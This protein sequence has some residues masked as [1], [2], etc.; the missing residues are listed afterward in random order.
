MPYHYSDPERE[1]ETYSLPDVETF[2]M[3][4]D[5]FVD[6]ESGSWMADLAEGN[7]P[8]SLAGWY[9][10][11]CFPGCVPEGDGVPW[12]PFDTEEEAIDDARDND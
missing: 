12:G 4:A 10:W 8:E 7:D 6:P 5:E 1:T 3:P 2:Y 11:H 9:Y